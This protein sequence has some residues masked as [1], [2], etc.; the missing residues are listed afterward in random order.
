MKKYTKHKPKNLI[1]DQLFKYVFSHESLTKYLIDAL[2]KYLS[3]DWDFSKVELKTQQ[4][5]PG[6]RHDSKDYYSD[7]MVVMKNSDVLLLEAYNRFRKK[8]FVKSKAYQDRVFSEQFDKGEE[9]ENP[10]RVIIVNFIRG[11]F[12][13]NKVLDKYGIVNLETLN[14]PIKSFNNCKLFIVI[15]VDK[16]PDGP[17]NEDDE[18]LQIV[19]F[20][21]CKD[22]AEMEEKVR[23]GGNKFMEESLAFVKAYMADKSNDNYGSHYQLELDYAYEDGQK[24]G[25]KN[26][27]KNNQIATAKRMIESNYSNEEITKISGLSINKINLLRKKMQL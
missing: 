17:Y 21:K 27:A 13:T 4:I 18:F 9:Y 23:E 11:N 24:D 8:E 25:M 7:L 19:N 10:K 6:K 26:G 16:C 5:I 1:D 3:I 20:M 12:D 14:E 2:S 22:V 15:K